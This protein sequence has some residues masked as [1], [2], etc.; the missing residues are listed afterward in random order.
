MLRFLR[1]DQVKLID[2]NSTLLQRL[3][4]DGWKQEVDSKA[5]G[6]LEALR[7]EAKALGVAFHHKSGVEKLKALIEEAKA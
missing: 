1:G 3:A 6:D 5:N 7:A 2:P 4:D